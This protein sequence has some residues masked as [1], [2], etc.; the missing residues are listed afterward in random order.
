MDSTEWKFVPVTP[1]GSV[2]THLSGETEDEAWANLLADVKHMPYVTK[3][4]LI[5]RGYTVEDWR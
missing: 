5:A 4:E 1:A 2:L 3:R